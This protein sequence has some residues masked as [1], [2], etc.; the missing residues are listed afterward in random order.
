MYHKV[1]PTIAACTKM[2]RRSRGEHHRRPCALQ[3][4][5]R[6][7]PLSGGSGS[8]GFGLGSDRPADAILR[9][10]TMHSAGLTGAVGCAVAGAARRASSGKCSVCG[11]RGGLQ[12]HLGDAERWDDAGPPTS[13]A[14][15]PPACA[16]PTAAAPCSSSGVPH[17]ECCHLLLW[18]RGWRRLPWRRQSWRQQRRRWLAWWERGGA[19]R[20]RRRPLAHLAALL[21][22]RAPC[23]GPAEP[24]APRW[25]GCCRGQARPGQHPGPAPQPF[26]D[27]ERGEQPCPGSPRALALLMSPPLSCLYPTTKM[28]PKHLV[29]ALPP[30]QRLCCPLLFPRCTRAGLVSL[31]L[32]L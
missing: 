4:N 31:C 13:V 18:W 19:R 12:L 17:A 2:S 6:H 15:R 20:R 29:F 11:R 14:C 25:Q 3:G 32:S 8:M 10:A 21:C 22:E 27:G 16:V 30:S 28:P 7:R 24:A 26:R 1:V 9:Q 5:C 23:H